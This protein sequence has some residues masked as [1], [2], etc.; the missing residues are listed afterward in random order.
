M[1]FQP[2]IAIVSTQTRLKG[3]LARW[4]TRSSAKFR[5]NQAQAIQRFAVAGTSMELSEEDQVGDFDEYEQEDI[6]YRDALQRIRHEVDIG[7]PIVMVPR[8]YLPNFDFL[9]CCAV[10]VVGPDG[11]VANTAKYVG[12]LPILG[13]NPDPQRFDGV[14]LPIELRQTRSILQRTLKDASSIREVTMGEVELND[15][16]KLLAFNDFFIGCRSHVSAR[17]TLQTEQGCEPQ[18]SSGVIVATGA[19]STGWLS[20]VF[21]MARGVTELSGGTVGSAQTMN[22]EDRRLAW[23]VRE[24]F[25]SRYSRADMIAGIL[26]EEH[27]LQLESMMPENGIIFS[28][29]IESDGLDFNSGSIA[30]VRV[31]QRRARLVVG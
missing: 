11:L 13:V 24:P 16:Q 27:R 22:W 30:T 18:S 3:L 10:I 4:G 1:G 5:L 7:F 2:S 20:S 6:S 8:E 14:L 15:G 19:G 26:E 21:N 12:A 29:G 25:T 17:Y 23:I 31:A 28:D 9:N